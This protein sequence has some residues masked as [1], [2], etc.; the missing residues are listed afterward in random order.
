MSESDQPTNP[1]NTEYLST[2]VVNVKSPLYAF[3]G[4]GRP[5]TVL[6]HCRCELGLREPDTFFVL[7]LQGPKFENKWFSVV[8]P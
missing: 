3:F 4:T 8:N 2:E 7:R 6:L 5:Y 1:G